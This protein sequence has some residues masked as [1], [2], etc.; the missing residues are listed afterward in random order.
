MYYL[1]KNQVFL[2]I[3]TA[4]SQSLPPQKLPLRNK[5]Y[6]QLFFRLCN[7]TRV[8]RLEGNDFAGIDHVISCTVFSPVN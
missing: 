1:K 2:R 4:L 7:I 5:D 3:P 8:F 6:I